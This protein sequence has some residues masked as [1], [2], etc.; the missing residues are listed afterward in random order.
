MTKTILVNALTLIR[1]PLSVMFCAEVLHNSSPFLPC[2]VLFL[3][4][5]TSDYLDGKLAR[6]FGAQTDIGAIMDVMTDLFFIVAACLSLSFRN[7]FPLWMLVVI[8]SKFLEFWVTS[9]IFN[10]SDKNTIIF[11]FDPFGRIVAVL[12][13]LLPILMLLLP[14]CLPDVAHRGALVMVCIGITGLTILS[15]TWRIS[16]VVNCKFSA[17]DSFNFAKIYKNYLSAKEIGENRR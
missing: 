11:L 10:R 14:L 8:L 16:S 2:A 5:G 15:S 4:I 13:Y 9:L 17:R 1:V 7:L 3:L 12:F 6:K